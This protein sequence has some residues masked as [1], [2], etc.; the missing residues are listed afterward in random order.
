MFIVGGFE[1]VVKEGDKFVC[2][3][4]ILVVEFV[5]VISFGSEEKV[6]N[7]E[8]ECFLVNMIYKVS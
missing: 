4:C 5:V 2:W 3:I 6:D 8:V 1:L 7:D